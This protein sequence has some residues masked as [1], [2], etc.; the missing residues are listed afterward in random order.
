MK[1]KI[2]CLCEKEYNE[3]LS[4]VQYDVVGQWKTSNCKVLFKFFIVISRKFMLLSFSVSRVKCVLEWTELMQLKKTWSCLVVP[5]KQARMS[6]IYQ[7]QNLKCSFYLLLMKIFF[8]LNVLRR[9]PREEGL[10]M[11]PLPDLLIVCKSSWK[12]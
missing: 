9:F 10:R 5:V 6:S 11:S 2:A 1:L 8:E 12:R 3:L 4:M 7:Y